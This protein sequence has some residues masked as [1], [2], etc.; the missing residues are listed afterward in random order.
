MDEAPSGNDAAIGAKRKKE[1]TLIYAAVAL[2][3]E[4][5]K[6]EEKRKNSN[7]VSL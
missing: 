6:A 7:L 5:A 1:K 2:T 4:R 3:K